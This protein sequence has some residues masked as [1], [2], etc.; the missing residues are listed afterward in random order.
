MVATCSASSRPPKLVVV[1][2]IPRPMADTTS[3]LLP[4]CRLFIARPLVPAGHGRSDDASAPA[5]PLPWEDAALARRRGASIRMRR[6]GASAPR[7]RRGPPQGRPAMEERV[8]FASEGLKLV[9]VLHLPDGRSARDPLPAF[10]VLHGFGSNKDSGG[11][12]ATAR[13]LAGF[14]YGALRFDMRGC[15]ES[16]GTRG[17]VICLEQ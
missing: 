17:R 7:R 1:L 3:P 5:S 2:P 8:T 4:S 10:L 14:G 6:R 11:S 13:M 15:G 12:M 9:G 16:D